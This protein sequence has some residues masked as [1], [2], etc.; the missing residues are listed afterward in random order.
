MML[1]KSAYMVNPFTIESYSFLYQIYYFIRP[2]SEVLLYLIVFLLHPRSTFP[3]ELPAGVQE[4]PE[5]SLPGVCAR[6]HPSL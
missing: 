6:L 3:Q 4:D 1:F 2:A 5:P